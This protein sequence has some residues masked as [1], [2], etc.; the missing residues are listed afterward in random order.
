[1]YKIGKVTK[2]YFTENEL[3][4]MEC[5]HVECCGLHMHPLYSFNICVQMEL[6]KLSLFGMFL[7]ARLVDV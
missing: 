5:I 1:M 3:V 2:L 4:L 7:Q 6:E